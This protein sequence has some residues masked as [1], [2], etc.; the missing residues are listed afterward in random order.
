M[1]Y[2]VDEFYVIWPSNIDFLP[3]DVHNADHAV[4]KC[5]SVRL[6]VCL[7]VCLSHAGIVS[8]RLN[9]SSNFFHR[10]VHAVLVSPY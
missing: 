5:L 10:R 3:R 4:A 1:A 8:K 2:S 7:P 9:M 6:Y